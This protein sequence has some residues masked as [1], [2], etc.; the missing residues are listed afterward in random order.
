MVVGLSESDSDGMNL[1]A[2]VVVGELLCSQCVAGSHVN[3]WH[4]SRVVAGRDKNAGKQKRSHRINVWY[5]VLKTFASIELKNL[6][7]PKTNPHVQQ[8][9][10]PFH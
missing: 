7:S 3:L 5:I 6:L 4:K 2:F 1:F 9:V 10:F 8:I